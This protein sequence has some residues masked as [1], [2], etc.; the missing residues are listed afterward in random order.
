MIYIVILNL[1]IDFIV[2][3]DILLLGSVNCMISDDKYVGGKGI[4]VSCILKCLKIDNI[5]IGFIG[6]FIGYFVEDGFVLEGIKIDFVFVNEDI[7]I[8]VKVKVKIE[9]EINGGGFRI[10]NE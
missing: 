8:N 9:I 2:C 5:V 1:L 3:L 4:N 7:C 10:I 6:G